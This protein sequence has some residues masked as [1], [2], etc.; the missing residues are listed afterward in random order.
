MTKMLRKL[1]AIMPTN[2]AVQKARA[3]AAKRQ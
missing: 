3:V 1:D 2:T